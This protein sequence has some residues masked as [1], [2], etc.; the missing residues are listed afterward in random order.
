MSATNPPT[1]EELLLWLK[2]TEHSFVERKVFSDSKDWLKTVVGFANTASLNYP[3]VLFI[4]AR[5]DGS[6]EGKTVDLDSV[7]KSL[8]EKISMAYPPIYTETKI[9]N[10][11]TAKV[12]AV[13]VP[14]SPNRPHFAGPAYV[15]DG[16]RT[17]VASKEQFDALIASRDSK[18]YE[19]LQ[20]RGKGIMFT[21]IARGELHPSSYSRA[22]VVDCN[23]HYVTVNV[24][25]GSFSVPLD[26]VHLGFDY[27]TKVL[28]LIR[29]PA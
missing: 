23:K 2:D 8:S 21:N 13:I 28:Q 25:G 26:R 5:N 16:A 14:G 18:A 27:E 19:I 24:G 4:G 22:S 17:V 29:L 1:E 12:L 7:Q 15:R 10:V 20:W 9:L 6:A 3:A 11:G